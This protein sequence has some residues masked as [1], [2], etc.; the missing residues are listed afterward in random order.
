MGSEPIVSCTPEMLRLLKKHKAENPLPSNR[1]KL[2]IRVLAQGELAVRRYV[3]KMLDGG[4]GGPAEQGE[5]PSG[6]RTGGPTQGL[7]RDS[8]APPSRCRDGMSGNV[9]VWRLSGCLPRVMNSFFITF[10]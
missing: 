2:P 9:S 4:A 5:A 3:E 10:F 6:V 7:L 8:H 1:G